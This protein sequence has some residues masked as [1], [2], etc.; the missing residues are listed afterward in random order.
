MRFFNNGTHIRV[1]RGD[2][3]APERPVNAE[4][5][6]IT[7]EFLLHFSREARPVTIENF[8]P[9]EILDFKVTLL[10]EDPFLMHAQSGER[11]GA[12]KDGERFAAF[13]GASISWQAEGK[14]GNC[15]QKRR[16]GRGGMF[17]VVPPI[18]VQREVSSPIISRG[19]TSSW[20]TWSPVKRP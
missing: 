15:Q 7:V 9:E 5:A 1:L 6:T 19:S 3:K 8:G 4:A 12:A 20:F 16:S 11:D 10:V 17:V 14:Q 18:S 13:M 2:G